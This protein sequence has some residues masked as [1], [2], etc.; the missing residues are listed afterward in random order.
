MGTFLGTTANVVSSKLDSGLPR[1]L[2]HTV[3][4]AMETQGRNENLQKRIHD[5]EWLEAEGVD[6]VRDPRVLQSLLECTGED[7]HRKRRDVIRLQNTAIKMDDDKAGGGKVN[8][9]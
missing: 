4:S 5:V 9:F 2:L 1:I 7:A 6:D 3:T 8:K